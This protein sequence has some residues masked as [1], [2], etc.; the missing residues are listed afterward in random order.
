MQVAVMGLE[1]AWQEIDRWKSGIPFPGVDPLLQIAIKAEQAIH[2]QPRA[3]TRHGMKK[4]IKI[5]IKRGEE[6]KQ[7]KKRK[8]R[9]RQD[10]KQGLMQ[11]N[12]DATTQMPMP[13]HLM[14]EKKKKRPGMQQTLV[15][16]NLANLR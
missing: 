5:K 10:M 13:H 4:K 11:C 3:R 7:R 15:H 14:Q 6:K 1:H 2:L 8:K 16:H 9:M 12:A